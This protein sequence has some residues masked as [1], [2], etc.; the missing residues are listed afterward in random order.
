M[1]CARL[2]CAEREAERGA[3]LVGTFAGA[4]AF[5]V[6]LLFAVQLLFN[7]YATSAVTAAG[8]MP[9]ASSPPSRWITPIRPPSKRPAASR[10]RRPARV[11]GRYGNHVSFG[12]QIDDD[13]RP[14][15]PPREEPPRVLR[16]AGFRHRIR[17]GRPHDQGA[18]GEIPMSL[19]LA[20]RHRQE[21]SGKVTRRGRQRCPRQAA[22]GGTTPCLWVASPADSAPEEALPAGRVGSG[23][24]HRGRCR[25]VCSSSSPERSHRQRVVGDRR[26]DG[27]DR[28]RTTRRRGPTSKRRTSRLAELPARRAADDSLRGHGRDP[29]A[30]A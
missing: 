25:S 10:R 16:R 8:S 27:G 13:V 15:A 28:C 2:P 26:Q 4:L 29:A 5:I 11:L 17:H 9:P 24:W 12:W 19:V 20:A 3:G 1:K 7:L 22:P 30:A 6:F 23:R 21:S 14:A 18:S